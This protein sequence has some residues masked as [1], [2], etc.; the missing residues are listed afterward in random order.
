MRW[1]LDCTTPTKS[2]RVST[3]IVISP[4]RHVAVTIGENTLGASVVPTDEVP[5]LG[6]TVASSISW[7]K[8]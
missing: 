7:Q 2:L 4:A 5:G 8:T 3:L 6:V 1:S